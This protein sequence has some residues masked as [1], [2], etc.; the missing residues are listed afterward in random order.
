LICHFRAYGK[1]DIDVNLLIEGGAM[2]CT[3]KLCKINQR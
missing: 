1:S 3:W 2:L